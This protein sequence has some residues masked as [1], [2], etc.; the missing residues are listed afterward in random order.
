MMCD[1]SDVRKSSQGD[2]GP[3]AAA[4]ID[5]TTKLVN[6]LTLGCDEE[7]K[8]YGLNILKAER[9]AIFPKD[10]CRMI[11]QQRTLCYWMDKSS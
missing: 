6:L 2:F 3:R 9:V 1:A 11:G 4:D 7:V 5:D 10:S 8:T